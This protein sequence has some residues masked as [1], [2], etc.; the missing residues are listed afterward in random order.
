MKITIKD[1]HPDGINVNFINVCFD[2]YE[3]MVE[4]IDCGFRGQILL[5][6][7]DMSKKDADYVCTYECRR[8][9]E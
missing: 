5:R 9:K 4:A 2:T 7:R 1:Q 6:Y 8:N 3:E